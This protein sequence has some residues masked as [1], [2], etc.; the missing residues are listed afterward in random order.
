M[1]AYPKSA[2][3]AA[4]ATLALLGLPSLAQA[5]VQVSA[6]GRAGVTLPTGDLSRDGAEAGLAVGAELMFTVQRNLSVYVGANRHG[7]SCDRDCD[8]G[9]NPRSSG[10]ASGLKVI[11]PS[12]ADAT[13]WARGGV[14]AH[15]IVTDDGSGPRNL[16]FELGTGFDMPIAPRLYLTPH[17]GLYSHDSRG[18]RSATYLNL[19][20][21]VHYHF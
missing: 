6:E 16:G 1:N 3:A 5:Q 12:P 13:L 17:L 14:L 9:R 2:A 15:R 8:V 20:V 21:G 7:F 10:L 4:L 18:S 19:G 11:F